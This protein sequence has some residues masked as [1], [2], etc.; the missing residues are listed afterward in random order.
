MLPCLLQ[1]GAKCNLKYRSREKDSPRW[2]KVQKKHLP[3]PTF[4]LSRTVPLSSKFCNDLA[5]KKSQHHLPTSSEK[6][7]EKR[8]S[9]FSHI[10]PQ[11]H[12]STNPPISN[13]KYPIPT[14]PSP[15]VPTPFP[16]PQLPTSNHHPLPQ[17]PQPIRIQSVNF[18]YLFVIP[19]V[20]TPSAFTPSYSFQVVSLPPLVYHFPRISAVG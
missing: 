18:P 15:R 13:I 17:Y 7:R 14:N 1:A 2:I 12:T 4:Y 19:D 6:T 10:P 3:A 5:H 9:S 16:P 8:F 20:I 11:H